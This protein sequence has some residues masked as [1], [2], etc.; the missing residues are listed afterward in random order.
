M[1]TPILIV[2]I[3]FS[4]TLSGCL[5]VDQHSSLQTTYSALSNDYPCQ[6]KPDRVAIYFEDEPLDFRYQKVGFI[7][8]RTGPYTELRD[9][10]DH[11]RYEARDHCANAVILVKR[12]IETYFD[13]SDDQE[14][15]IVTGLAVTA[16]LPEIEDDGLFVSRIEEEIAVQN[17]NSGNA[18]AGGF[19]ALVIVVMALVFASAS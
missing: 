4:G 5:I 3:L 11:I 19:M 1:K 13:G 10:M 14:R 15:V 8:I 9:I 16:N 17:A 6:S 2:T 7:E 18:T 12:E